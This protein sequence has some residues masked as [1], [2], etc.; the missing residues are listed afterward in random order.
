MLNSS[1][2]LCHHTYADSCFMARLYINNGGGHT[3]DIQ[4]HTFFSHATCAF[5]DC[6]FFMKGLC[7]E[8]KQMVFN[9]TVV[10][11]DDMACRFNDGCEDNSFL[12]PSMPSSTRNNI[13]E[14]VTAE[15]GVIERYNHFTHP[16]LPVS[17]PWSVG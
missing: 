5:I 6:I 8:R 3:L 16:L 4:D 11:V 7:R 1:L 12:T 14:L 2:S 10:H 13:S 17:W 15:Y 9:S